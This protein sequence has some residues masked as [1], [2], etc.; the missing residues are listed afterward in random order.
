MIGTFWEI[1]CLYRLCCLLNHSTFWGIRY[2][3]TFTV[4]PYRHTCM[5]LMNSW[6]EAEEHCQ[7]FISCP[8]RNSSLKVCRVHSD[9]G[10]EYLGMKNS[11]ERQGITLTVRTA[12]SPKSNGLAEELT[13]LQWKT[14][15]RCSQQQILYYVVEAKRSIRR[16]NFIIASSHP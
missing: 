14:S 8:E 1:D 3:V 5:K 16:Y 12:Y 6:G 13:A 10:G 2:F 9:K 4:T 15:G 11:L 7:N